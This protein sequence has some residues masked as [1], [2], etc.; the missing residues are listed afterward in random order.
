MRNGF[1]LIGD[2]TPDDAFYDY[3]MKPDEWLI[4]KSVYESEENIL[5]VKCRL[6]ADV[7]IFYRQYGNEKDLAT[8]RVIENYTP[9]TECFGEVQRYFIFKERNNGHTYRIKQVRGL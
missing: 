4:R 1:I 2:E 7:K 8:A 9:T 6:W 5:E 3:G